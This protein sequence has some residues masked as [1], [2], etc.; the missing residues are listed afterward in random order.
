MGE[1]LK[2]WGLR[3]IL[4]DFSL[5]PRTCIAP[6]SR[7]KASS[8]FIYLHLAAKICG[9]CRHKILLSNSGEQP[10]AMARDYIVLRVSKTTLTN[11]SYEKFPNLK[12]GFAFN[13]L[14][15][16]EASLSTYYSVC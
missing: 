14:W 6:S 13:N 16:R 8:S 15:L 5:P 11:N 3:G 12:V 4:D 1:T 7:V 10:R 9:I 2:M